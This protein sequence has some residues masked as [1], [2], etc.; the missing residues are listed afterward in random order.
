ML[1]P[2][3]MAI[4]VPP[5]TTAPA[6]ILMYPNSPSLRRANQ[7]GSC[8]GSLETECATP[9]CQP[10]MGNGTTIKQCP[11]I[12]YGRLSHSSAGWI[13]C[14]PV[15]ARNGTRNPSHRQRGGGLSE[16]RVRRP[17]NPHS[18]I[19]ECNG[20]VTPTVLPILGNPHLNLFANHPV[21]VVFLHDD[22][23]A[24]AAQFTTPVA[25]VK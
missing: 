20:D 18:A 24:P 22:I 16:S 7:I 13:P 4:P 9:A 12:I 11:T 8:F 2:A 17:E 25:K 3:A 23:T 1:A 10:G 19:N 21:A 6:S 5:A 15:S 14:L